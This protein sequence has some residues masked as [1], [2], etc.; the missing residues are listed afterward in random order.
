[1]QI[2]EEGD[3]KDMGKSV[4]NVLRVMTANTQALT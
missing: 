1:M 4:E 3:G 2:V